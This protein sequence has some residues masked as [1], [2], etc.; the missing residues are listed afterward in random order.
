MRKV[1]LT[2]WRCNTGALRFYLQKC[3][4]WEVDG[5]SPRGVEEDEEDEMGTKAEERKGYVILSLKCK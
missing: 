3:K 1:M 2:C 5:I 4:G